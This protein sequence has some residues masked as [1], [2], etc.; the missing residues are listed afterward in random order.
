MISAAQRRKT[1]KT[2]A[3]LAAYHRWRHET[4]PCKN[5]QALACDA[6]RIAARRVASRT[7]NILVPEP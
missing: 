7:T 5:R 4:Q 2:S 6:R 3:N 1:A